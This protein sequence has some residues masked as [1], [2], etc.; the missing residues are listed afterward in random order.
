MEK[1][2]TIWKYQKIT[3]LVLILF[4][5]LS[6]FL[7]GNLIK[8]IVTANI[9]NIRLIELLENHSQFDRKVLVDFVLKIVFIKDVVITFITAILLLFFFTV[10]RRVVRDTFGM[11]KVCFI[12]IF[13]ICL[14]GILF[15]D[16]ILMNHLHM[17]STALAI[18]YVI[19]FIILTGMLGL[20]IWFVVKYI[21]Y[22]KENDIKFFTHASIWN[23]ANK[24]IRHFSAIVLVV[25]VLTGVG[26]IFLSKSVQYII[27]QLELEK[28]LGNQIH[29]NIA[30]IFN[31]LPDFLGK[32]IQM[33][34]QPEHLGIITLD[35][36]TLGDQLQA[37]LTVRVQN[38]TQDMMLLIVKTFG[39]YILIESLNEVHQY[40]KFAIN[41]ITYALLLLMSARIIFFA[42]NASFFQIIDMCLLIA[43][44]MYGATLVDWKKHFSQL[45]Q[46]IQQI[47][48]KK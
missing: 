13:F 9:S 17:L 8:D 16:Y 37:L 45:K 19:Q 23:L 29:I 46:K 3:L 11:V 24:M 10:H 36:K 20:F 12:A 15:I 42:S 30:E 33:K 40:K 38:Y 6:L 21:Q 5:V 47:K 43:V 28:I 4:S 1:I 41:Y 27:A 22:R 18:K 14:Y 31:V 39:F 48:Q 7:S 2:K 35:V 34:F 44:L 26:L 32:I 25:L